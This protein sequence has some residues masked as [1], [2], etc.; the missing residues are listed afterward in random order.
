M[1]SS[2]R[3]V[4]REM[5][6]GTGGKLTGERKVERQAK[7][8]DVRS[9]ITTP[10]GEDFGRG[11]GEC[12]SQGAGARDAELTVELGGAEVGE[13][14]SAV[15]LEENVGGFDV[16]MEDAAAVR[17][18]QSG[19][20]VAPYLDRL[21]G[22]E[23][24]ALA[25]AHLQVGTCDVLHDDEAPRTVFQKIEDRD[26][27]RVRQAAHRLHLT[28]HPFAGNLRRGGGRD[29]ELDRDIAADRAIPREVH[30]GV[31]AAA[32]LAD[33]LVSAE[34]NR[35]RIEKRRRGHFPSRRLRTSRAL[36]RQP[37]SLG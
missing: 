29:E 35:P 5:C 6:R 17:R 8:V 7:R 26:D 14:R 28:A 24:P 32:E 1:K 27:V 12:S 13:T 11:V 15:G 2:L 20:D 19:G 37:S 31:P 34:E 9:C 16:A 18:R 30:D 3:R 25:H 10:S 22:V 21:L 4:R 33:D 36:P 23:R